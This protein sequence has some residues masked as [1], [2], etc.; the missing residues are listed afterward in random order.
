MP[1][2]IAPNPQ[3]GQQNTFFLTFC[4]DTLDNMTQS[5]PVAN[6]PPRH[7]QGENPMERTKAIKL[8][9][10]HSIDYYVVAETGELRILE[11][12]TF[13]GSLHARFVPCPS[14]LADLMA[15][16]GY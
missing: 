3:S 5:Y 4:L 7:S 1:P 11:A 8:L 15:W 16:L 13:G 2:K 6:K 12:F 10:L 9:K 14:T